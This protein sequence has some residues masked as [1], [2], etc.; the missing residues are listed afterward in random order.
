MLAHDR[1]DAFANQHGKVRVGTEAPV[2]ENDIALEEHVQHLPENAAFV[3]LQGL[4][5]PVDNST[6]C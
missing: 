1:I 6:G 5:N 3:T 4:F 2:G